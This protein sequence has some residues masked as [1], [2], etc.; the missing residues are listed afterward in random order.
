MDIK[1]LAKAFLLAI[2]VIVILVVAI[3]AMVG[4]AFLGS[5][6]PDLMAGVALAG[7]I[8]FLTV[9]FYERLKKDV[10]NDRS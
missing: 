6:F 3:I 1:L 5:K 7:I 10:E 2:A 4:I 9:V 8:G